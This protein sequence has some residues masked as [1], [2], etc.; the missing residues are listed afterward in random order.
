MLVID[1]GPF[2]GRSENVSSLVFTTGDPTCKIKQ[3]SV[4]IS[5]L[6]QSKAQNFI[7]ASMTSLCHT[8][9]DLCPRGLRR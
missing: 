7:P 2:S 6:E 8:P 5:P 9:V 1:I 4:E 3:V